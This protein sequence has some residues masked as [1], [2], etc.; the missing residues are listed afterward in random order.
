[1]RSLQIRLHFIILYFLIK[2]GAIRYL[3]FARLCRYQGTKDLVK[4]NYFELIL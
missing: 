1:M 4:L 2:Q 3:T